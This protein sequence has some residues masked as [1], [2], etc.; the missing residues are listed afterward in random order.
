[1]TK[2]LCYVFAS[3]IALLFWLAPRPTAAQAQQQATLVIDGGTLI[4]GSGGAP[5]PNALIIIQG[6]RITNVSRKGQISYP[7]T[8]QVIHADGKF[9]LPGFWEAETV[10]GWFGGESELIHGVTSISDIATKSEVAMLHKEAVNRGKTGGPRTFIGT[11]YLGSER[12]TG[13]ETPFERAQVPKSAAEAREVAKRFIAA[14]SDM[15]M[16][17]DGGLPIEYYQAAFDEEELE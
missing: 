2:T 6:N 3:C 7:S 11:G 10:Y 14:G 8:A 9:I 13:F 4:D 5:V 1:M 15:V 16:F 12:V 17:F